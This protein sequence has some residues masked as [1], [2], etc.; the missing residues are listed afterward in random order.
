[1]FQSLPHPKLSAEPLELG[2]YQ[3]N[4][5]Q[6]LTVHAAFSFGRLH[7]PGPVNEAL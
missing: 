5:T 2:E 4:Q 1:M 3:I 6:H 7:R